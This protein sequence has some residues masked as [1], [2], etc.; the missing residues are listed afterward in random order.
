MRSIQALVAVALALPLAAC[1]ASEARAVESSAPAAAQQTPATDLA[2]ANAHFNAGEWEKAIQGYDAVLKQDPSQ[3]AAWFRLGYALHASGKLE[4]ACEV[5]AKAAEFPQFAPVAVYNLGCAR[6]LLGQP[7]AAF[8]ALDRAVALG[9][10][11]VGQLDG[12]AV[13]ASLHADARWANLRARVAGETADDPALR[14]MDFWVGE[15]DVTS[16]DGQLLGTNSIAA[17]LKGHLIFERW[18]GARGDSGKSMNYWDRGARLWR[19]VWVSDG[20]NVLQMAGAFT[21]GALRF[22]GAT[23]YKTGATVKHRTTLLPLA[24]GRV[25][26][27]IEESRDDGATWTVGFDGWYAKRKQQ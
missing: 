7:D 23:M 2:A 22:E 15:W 9:F 13:L 3:G 8:A 18:T 17:E 26:Q 11:D 5:H 19:Q 4:R 21:D 10:R 6:A 16:A 20:G 12:D 14:Q 25:H 1:A 27:H 24:D